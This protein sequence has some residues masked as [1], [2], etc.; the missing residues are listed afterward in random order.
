MERTW[1]NVITVSDGIDFSG[2]EVV[3]RVLNYG[4]QI[5]LMTTGMV[6]IIGC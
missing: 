4:A 3:A 1:Q 6:V 5:G 2:F